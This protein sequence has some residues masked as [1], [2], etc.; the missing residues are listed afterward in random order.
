MPCFLCVRVAVRDPILGRVIRRCGVVDAGDEVR[1]GGLP[2]HKKKKRKV[3][4]ED[5][6][7]WTKGTSME[8][9]E[10]GFFF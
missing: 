5:E 4:K 2:H 9:R 7:S 10:V 3:E 8:I 6:T 1:L